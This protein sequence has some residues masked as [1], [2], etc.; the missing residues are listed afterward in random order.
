[1][2]APLRECLDRRGDDTPGVPLPPPVSTRPAADGGP[3][4]S[5]VMRARDIAPAVLFAFDLPERSRGA[6]VQVV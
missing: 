5:H 1:M 6:T 3:D 4:L 2:L